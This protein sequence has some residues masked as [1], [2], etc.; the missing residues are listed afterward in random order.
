MGGA[1]KQIFPY[2]TKFRIT[3]EAPD[4]TRSGKVYFANFR[5]DELDYTVSIEDV[6]LRAHTT[7]DLK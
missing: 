4:A 3:L 5:L 1:T 7:I 6:I 2:S